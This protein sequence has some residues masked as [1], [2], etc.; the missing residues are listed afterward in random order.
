MNYSHEL[1]EIRNRIHREI[2]YCAVST[3]NVW[4]SILEFNTPQE[5]AHVADGIAARTTLVGVDAKTGC[6]IDDNDDVIPYEG[7]PL[8]ILG[9]IHNMLTS[10]EFSLKPDLFL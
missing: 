2:V 9:V 6:L 3:Y 8:E 10:K 5:F 1:Q 4:D 7:V